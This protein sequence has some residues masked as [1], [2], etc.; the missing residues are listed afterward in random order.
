MIG[1][2]VVNQRPLPPMR[3]PRKNTSHVLHPGD[4]HQ[5][6]PTFVPK[7][8]G[9]RDLQGHDFVQEPV[10]VA[11]RPWTTSYLLNIYYGS[12]LYRCTGWP[13]GEFHMGTAGH[14]L[15]D[16][17]TRRF[18][19]LIIAFPS[20]GG[21]QPYGVA[22]S[23]AM[24]VDSR[25]S[26]AHSFEDGQRW[27]TSMVRFD[28]RIGARTN[29][30]SLSD[31]PPLFNGVSVTGYPLGGPYSGSVNCIYSTAHVR[32][33]EDNQ[34]FTSSETYGGNSGGAIYFTE[35]VTLT[36]YIIGSLSGGSRGRAKNTDPLA[37]K[38]DFWARMTTDRINTLTARM[39][40]DE[41]DSTAVPVPKPELV[42]LVLGV[43]PNDPTTLL[44]TPT[45]CDKGEQVAQA[46][47]EL[48]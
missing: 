2:D 29:W 14:C 33:V 34:L 8:A 28:R 6:R 42:Q 36:R 26:N 21:Y 40:E 3:I 48:E 18:A 20:T 47:F 25:Y 13:V 16:H 32:R 44:F 27:D 7:R 24:W 39:A 5:S 31:Q 1:W 46:G 41:A 4:V 37:G 10:A 11:Q 38:Y 12:D 9:A 43:I 35:K 19:D 23:T 22:K 30:D 17:D 15:F 45:R